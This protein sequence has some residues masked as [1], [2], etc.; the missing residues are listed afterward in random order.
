MIPLDGYTE[1]VA[2][3]GTPAATPWLRKLSDKVTTYTDDDGDELAPGTLDSRV[4]PYQAYQ[5][6]LTETQAAAQDARL[7]ALDLTTT[8]ADQ[9]YVL[10]T[11]LGTCGVAGEEEGVVEEFAV[12][13]VTFD[14]DRDHAN[15]A[16]PLP[17]PIPELVGGLSQAAVRGRGPAPRGKRSFPPSTRRRDEGRVRAKSRDER[18]LP[19]FE[20]GEQLPVGVPA[21]HPEPDLPSERAKVGE[22]RREEAT[23]VVGG[24]DISGPELHAEQVPRVRVGDERM[25]A[26]RPIVA[27]VGR[28]VLLPM[29]R[30]REG[31]DVEGDLGATAVRGEVPSAR[32]L[33]QRVGEH[34]AVVRTSEHPLRPR[35]RGLRG[36]SVRRPRVL[37]LVQRCSAPPGGHRQSERRI[38]PEKLGIALVLPALRQEEDP[39]EHQ[40]RQRVRHKVLRP[41]IDD[42][43]EC[44]RKPKPLH[45]L[46]KDQ[47]A[48]VPGDGARRGLNTHRPVEVRPKQTTLLHFTHLRLRVG[49]YTQRKANFFRH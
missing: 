3:D 20:P 34:P 45:H 42:R 11:G 13:G 15:H 21:V 46:P 14:Q 27:V 24:V 12:R 28:S 23:D 7:A 26:L 5:L 10:L 30:D 47:R 22:E 38:M 35:Q 37:R 29:G 33:G 48:S 19:L 1:V 40:L 49:T 9:G 8:T 44:S 39:R 41:M 2:W 36:K 43:P 6:A 32:T 4:L 18:D 31:V 17:W 16:R 25:E